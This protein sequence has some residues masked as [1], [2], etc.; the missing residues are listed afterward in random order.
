MEKFNKIEINREPEFTEI[1]HKGAV[2]HNGEEHPFW[3]INPQGKDE[4]GNEYDCEIRWFFQRVPM[5][6]RA[7]YPLIIKMFRENNQDRKSIT[8]P[9]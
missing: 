8:H 9:N 4:Y 3:L 1:W 6:V 2:T 5:E 7:M